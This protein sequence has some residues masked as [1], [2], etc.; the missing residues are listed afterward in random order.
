[1][2]SIIQVG[3]SVFRIN[4]V[5]GETWLYAYGSWVLVKEPS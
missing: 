1:M 2:Y 3:E 4:S 5:T